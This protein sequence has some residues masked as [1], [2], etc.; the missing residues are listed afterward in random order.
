MLQYQYHANK[1]HFFATG[2]TT[3]LFYYVT[4]DEKAH[5]FI[6]YSLIAMFIFRR[7][8]NTDDVDVKIYFCS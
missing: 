7:N 4:D 6:E 2:T 3:H 8:C 5:F 1:M